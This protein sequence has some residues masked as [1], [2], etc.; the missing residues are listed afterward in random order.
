MLN[1]PVEVIFIDV[2]EMELDIAWYRKESTCAKFSKME[3]K[4]S[5]SYKKL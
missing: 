4:F 3:G 2:R 5:L 1:I